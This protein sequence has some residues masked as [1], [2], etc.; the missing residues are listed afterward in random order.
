MIPCFLLP[1]LRFS[2]DKDEST[3]PLFSRLL[4]LLPIKVSTSGFSSDSIGEDMRPGV[5]VVNKDLQ[6]KLNMGLEFIKVFSRNKE[7][8]IDESKN[9]VGIPS[10]LM[11]ELRP[12]QKEGI[13][14]MTALA[15]FGL[16]CALCD[17]MGLG[18]TLQ[19]LS[20][21][22]NSTLE[23]IKSSPGSDIPVSLIV[24]PSTLTHNWIY[25]YK[26]FFS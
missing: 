21:I 25:E 5:K 16:S 20:V 3:M 11:A 13:A 22:I 26:K 24:C 17:D 12:Y 15:K 10:S 23:S 2:S 14:W 7:Y 18:K 6:K 19:T 1:V 9:G 4:K 8:I